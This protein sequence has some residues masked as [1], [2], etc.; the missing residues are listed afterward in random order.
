[1]IRAVGKELGI[2]M[3]VLE[4]RPLSNHDRTRQ[5]SRKVGRVRTLQG[6]SVGGS[7][8]GVRGP[9]AE[10]IYRLGTGRNNDAGVA[11]DGTQCEGC[12]YKMRWGLEKACGWNFSDV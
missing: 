5:P 2:Q 4:A 12:G 3:E 9:G 6:G 7:D 8:V 11:V 10:G 1:M